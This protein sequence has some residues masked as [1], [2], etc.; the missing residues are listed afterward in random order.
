[1]HVF[2]HYPIQS[3]HGAAVP[4]AVAAE[5]AGEQGK[6]WPMHDFLF[7]RRG[8]LDPEQMSVG[9]KELELAPELFEACLGGPAKDKVAR[10]V[11]E[12]QALAIRSTPSFFVGLVDRAG[13]VRVTARFGGIPAGRKLTDAL[14]QAIAAAADQK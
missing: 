13:R 4:A 2:R 1:M 9:A 8:K 10:D 5:C 12:A 11:L 3:I 14:D 6:F 7:S